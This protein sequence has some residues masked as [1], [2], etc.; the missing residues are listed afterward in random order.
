MRLALL[1]KD[2]QECIGTNIKTDPEDFK[3]LAEVLKEVD[4]EKTA[5]NIED[6]SS[7]SSEH[8]QNEEDDES[9]YAG[10]IGQD[11]GYQQLD[12]SGN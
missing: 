4:V 12:E 9:G 7:E 1:D 5:K 3:G 6:S 8:S 11:T 2:Y 10:L